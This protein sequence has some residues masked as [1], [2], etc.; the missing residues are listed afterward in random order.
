MGTPRN[1]RVLGIVV[2]ALGVLGSITSVSV[3]LSGASDGAGYVVANLTC[4][5]AGVALIW[6][7]RKQIEH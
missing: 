4:I 5:A 2:F 3:V 1:R 6:S 7:S